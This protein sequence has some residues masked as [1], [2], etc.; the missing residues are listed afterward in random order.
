MQ[1]SWNIKVKSKNAAFPQRFV[2]LG[3]DNADGTYDGVEGSPQINV[4]G[5]QWSITVQHNPTGPVSWIPS[6]ER[7]SNPV[8]SSGQIKFD[9]LTNDTG[10]DQDYNDLILTCSTSANDAEFVLYGR[11]STYKGQCP[12]NPCSPF[13]W[14]I[15]DSN[16]S[17][18]KLL[19]YASIRAALEKIYPE[20]VREAERPVIIRHP[21]PEPDPAP[22]RPLM[23]PLSMPA[24]ETL[25]P[26]KQ[27]QVKGISKS[28]NVASSFGSS[29]S[30]SGETRLAVE[31]SVY[32]EIA[33][34]AKDI[35]KLKDRFKLPCTVKRRPGMLLRFLEY[36]R[37]SAELAGGAYSGS[38]NRQ[39]L[40]L[41]VT[42]EQGNYIFR[43]TRTL[44]DIAEEM[45]DIP[46]GGI[47]VTELR[48][49]II[50]QVV[51][52]IGATTGVLFETALYPNIP[53]LKR[54]D[55]CIPESS[56]NP[57]SSSCQGGRAIQAIGNV[58]VSWGGNTW[59]ADGRITATHPSG[60]QITRGAWGGRLDMF[61]CF[62][63]HPEITLYTIRYRKPGVS[64][65]FVNEVYTHIYIPAIGDI[66][67]PLHKVGPFDTSLSVDGG[68]LI[69][70]P[71]YKNIESSPDWIVTHRIRKAQLRSAIYAS[72]LYA[73]G[74]GTVEFWIE[75][76]DSSGNKVAE[77]AIKLFIDN[78]PVSGD[79]ASISM[80][81]VAP[82]ECSLFNLPT[83]NE[84]LTIRFKVDQP[85]GFLKEYH[86][87]VLRGSANQVAVSDTSPP[88]QPL[89]LS[90]D[91]GT[92]GNFFY[93]TH[94]AIGPDSDGYVLAELQPVSGAWLPADKNFCAFAFE[95]HATPR[96]TDGY[97]LASGYRLDLE[98]VGISYSP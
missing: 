89:S 42:D 96:V 40:G 75:G 3:S 54:I 19:Q 41:T 81:G 16:A 47:A 23:I 60:P 71:A 70:V 18:K 82:G 49:D 95:I 35:A 58:F 62:L 88:A 10:G 20:R 15:I 80:G 37:T 30:L 1:G 28:V 53:N 21:F 29:A 48:P 97:G 36:D 14:V 50:V 83:P 87:S 77:D 76:Y 93:G 68:P 12:F 11:M 79:I 45:G 92:H 84:T 63:D 17:L 74:A 31:A 91:E 39:I 6:A 94:D 65:S 85:G 24:E 25:Q 27:S 44:A 2:I 9:I 66:Y 43:F 98:L 4:T 32:T 55:L 51:S 59:D 38:G 33:P 7:L 90:Y 52:G 61:A 5:T 46:S 8:L 22:F 73:D 78:R 67:S 56:I 13:P 69:T 64:W 72:A 34:Y 57:G 26:L 86:L